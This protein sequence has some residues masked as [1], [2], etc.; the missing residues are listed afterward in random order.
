MATLRNGRSAALRRRQLDR[1]VKPLVER[2]PT[3]P[4]D[5]WIAAI[6]DAIGM[7]RTQLAQRMG[8][9]QPSLLELERAEANGQIS[10]DRLE[11]AARALNCHVVYAVVPNQGSLEQMVGDQ[12]DKVARDIVERTAH[13]MALE[14]QDID[15][16]ERDARAA[17]IKN[18]LM[19]SPRTL[20]ND[21]ERE[22]Q[23]PKRNHVG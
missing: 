21:A 14:S 19:R 18:E 8:I 5:G 13:S 3:R 17:E 16:D 11:R 12:A 22:A 1:E 7:T 23:P 15:T 4:S 9:K 6:R 20:W 10:L 2:S